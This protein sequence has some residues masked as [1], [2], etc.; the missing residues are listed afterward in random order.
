MSHNHLH[1]AEHT[2]GTDDIQSAT[3]A[4]KGLATDSHITAVEANTAHAAVVTGNPHQATLEEARTKNNQIAGDIDANGHQVTGLGSPA[5]TGDAATK[6]YVDGLVQGL[7]WQESVIDKDLNDPPGVPVEGDR[8]IVAAGGINA[9]SGHDEEIAE[10]ISAAWVFTTPTEGAAVWVEDENVNYVYN[11]AHPAGSWVTM[12]STTD[13]G[14]LIGLGDDDHTQY[15]KVDGTR[16]MAAGLDMGTFAITNVGLVDG[17]D[18][19][20]HAARHADGGA[21]ELSV[22]A[23]SGV[24]ADRQTP[25]LHAAEHEVGG[26]DLVDH[27]ALTNYAANEHI[28]WT[29]AG[30]VDFST[31]GDVAAVEGHFSGEVSIQVFAQVGEPALAADGNMAIWKDTDDTNRIYLVFRRGAADQVLVE[32]G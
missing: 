4:Q 15:L 10:W 11:G 19:S 17:V 28:D 13:H 22:A 12:G 26:D 21:D 23:L 1:K 6:G 5:D 20:G 27:D 32:L 7:D 16:A 2:D 24:L 14:N 30:A 9:W 25:V 31:G 18:I 8:Y 29:A 3:N